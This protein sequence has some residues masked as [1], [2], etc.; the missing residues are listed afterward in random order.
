VPATSS[1]EEV[2][3]VPLDLDE[4]G[5]AGRSMEP[6]FPSDDDDEIKPEDIPF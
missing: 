5:N 6:L 3:I 2:T 4:E 1:P